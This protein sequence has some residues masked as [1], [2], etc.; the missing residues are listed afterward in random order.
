MGAM[1]TNGWSFVIFLCLMVLLAGCSTTRGLSGKAS[2]CDV[3]TQWQ[4]P[5]TEAQII[6]EKAPY[7]AAFL[8]KHNSFGE[9]SCGW[10]PPQK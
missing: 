9:Q 7:T 5:R 2:F 1:N 4:G 8:V 3:S 10:Q 6:A